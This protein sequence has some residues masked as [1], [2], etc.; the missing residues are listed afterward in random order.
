[1]LNAPRYLCVGE[2]CAHGET[3]TF[4]LNTPKNSLFPFNRNALER[5][6]EQIVIRTKM[7]MAKT[8]NNMDSHSYRNVHDE[9]PYKNNMDSHSYK[10]MH[11]KDQ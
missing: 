10:N 11:D 9:N 1:M 4:E 6:C 5:N 8:Q 3:E 2:R 7:Y